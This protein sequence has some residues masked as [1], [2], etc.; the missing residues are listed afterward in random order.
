MIIILYYNPVETARA[1]FP[2]HRR[3][4]NKCARRKTVG[5]SSPDGSG[6]RAVASIARF[7]A[8]HALGPKGGRVGEE[9]EKKFAWKLVGRNYAKYLSFSRMLF[10][11]IVFEKDFSHPR[12]AYRESAAS[13]NRLARI[14]RR[15]SVRDRTA[16]FVINDNK[17]VRTK[18]F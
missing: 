18:K 3:V 15:G 11:S 4:I 14:Y 13:W 8:A 6:Q 5:S 12:P 2:R 16:G 1:K 7:A 17:F 9:S 10:V